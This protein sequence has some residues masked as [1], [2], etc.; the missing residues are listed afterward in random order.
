MQLRL[1]AVTPTCPLSGV[2]QPSESKWVAPPGSC[3]TNSALTSY[4]KKNSVLLWQ[5]HGL[6]VPSSIP[7]DA[8]GDAIVVAAGHGGHGGGALVML[9]GAGG[10]GGVCAVVDVD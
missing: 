6:H 8:E 1:K 7:G 3:A 10:Y 4:V 5:P 9:L 2:Q